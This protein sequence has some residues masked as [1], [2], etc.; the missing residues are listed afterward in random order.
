MKWKTYITPKFRNRDML[1]KAS[2]SISKAYAQMMKLW[3]QIVNR[4][5]QDNKSTF[6]I[7]EGTNISNWLSFCDIRSMDEMPLI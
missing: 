1:L 2:L 3:K 7:C 5:F 6:K 4:L